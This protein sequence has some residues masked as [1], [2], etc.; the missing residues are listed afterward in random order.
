MAS[1]I[2][3]V[4]QTN[5]YDAYVEQF[6]LPTLKAME[7][8]FVVFLLVE[9]CK[10]IVLTL[11]AVGLAFVAFP[12]V[13]AQSIFDNVLKPVYFF[14]QEVAAPF[15]HITFDQWLT[16]INVVVY[17]TLGMQ[18]MMLIIMQSTLLSTI[19]N[20]VGAV[21]VLVSIPYII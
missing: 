3:S 17:T 15:K 20:V 21:I 7:E 9:L 18:I 2:I 10:S 6:I 1:K 4:V 11:F 13:L 8:Y 19:V 16:V 5:I 12:V 14:L